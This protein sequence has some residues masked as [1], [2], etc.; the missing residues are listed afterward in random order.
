VPLRCG[1]EATRARTVLQ[2]RQ[3]CN[4]HHAVTLHYD[5]SIAEGGEPVRLSYAGRTFEV[6]GSGR[7]VVWTGGY[8]RG[9]RALTVEAPDPSVA[10]DL[11]RTA[12]LAV[13]TDYRDVSPAAGRN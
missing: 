8:F 4:A 11:L 9:T 2:V 10:E 5:G 1:I 13:T 3:D 7:T 6:D 12:H